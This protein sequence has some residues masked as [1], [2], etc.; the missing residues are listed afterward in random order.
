MDTFAIGAKDFLLNGDPF[1]ILS[2]AVHYFRV[3]PDQWQDRIHKARLMGLNTIETYVPWNEHSPTPGSFVTEGGLDLGRFLDLVHA[4]GMRAIVRPGPYICAEWDNGGLPAWLFTDP[5]TG[6]RSSEPG[7]LAAVDG[8]MDALLPIVVERQITRGGPVILLQIENEYGAYGSDKAYLQHLVDGAKRSG[9]DV[10][11]ITC[12]QPFGT[13]IEDGS[14]PGL[15]KTATFG[16]RA[17]E[18]LGFLRE[19]QPTGPLMCAEFWNGWFDNWGSHHHTTD[20]A[21]SAADLD[22]L[23]AAGASVNLY[24]FHGGTNFGFTNGANDKGIYQP[25]ITSY[26]YDAPLAEDGHPTDKYFAFRDVIARHFPVPG[27][28]PDPRPTAPDLLV[29]MSSG[30]SLLEAAALPSPAVPG[31][32]PVCEVTG[33]YRGFFLY[34]RHMPDGGL[35][36]FGEIRDRAQFYLDGS[37]LGSLSRDLGERSLVLPRGGLLQILVEDQGRVNYGPRIGE[38]KGLMGPALLDGVEVLDWAVCPVDLS[39]LERFRATAMDLTGTGG[40]AG[41]VMAFASFT[42]EGPGD[43]YLRLDCWTKGNAFVN[44]FNLGRYW[45]RGPQR[46]L[47]VPG[48]LIRQGINELAILEL[49]GSATRQVR[50]VPGPDL[51]P[52]EA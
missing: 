43:R 20:A 33:T 23:L 46:T 2:G 9:V 49:Q 6:I 21:A 45:S 29:S 10:P 40:I 27:E 35:L 15:H 24:M 3:H 47:Y 4:E 41:P 51:G 18:R 22:A 19:R 25:T 5:S 38:A 26:D 34:E 8:F 17:P 50:F 42:A 48:P 52:S 11:L 36:T 37:P 39:T 1:R 32:V 12:D 44:G 16:S 30:V 31:S 7:Y 28:V 13:M 14:L